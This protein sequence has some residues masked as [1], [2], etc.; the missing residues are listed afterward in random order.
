MEDFYPCLCSL[1]CTLGELGGGGGG[2]GGGVEAGRI[3][4]CYANPQRHLGFALL[5]RILPTL[6]MFR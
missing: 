4:E 1:I 3:L 2:G 6:R 5:S